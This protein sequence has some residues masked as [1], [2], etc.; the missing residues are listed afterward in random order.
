MKKYYDIIKESEKE[1]DLPV[2]EKTYIGWHKNTKEMIDRTWEELANYQLMKFASDI[3][4]DLLGKDYQRQMLYLAFLRTYMKDLINHSEDTLLANDKT[5]SEIENL[6]IEKNIVIEFPLLTINKLDLF[7]YLDNYFIEACSGKK[8]N[9][10]F[11]L[12]INYSDE[13]P[14]DHFFEFRKYRNLNLLTLNKNKNGEEISFA[15][16]KADEELSAHC[17]TNNEFV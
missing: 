17:Y 1:L 7:L 11:M 14:D 15:L 13:L 10:P 4:L 16:K 3:H 2:L 5:F 6:M 12:C 9:L 8:L